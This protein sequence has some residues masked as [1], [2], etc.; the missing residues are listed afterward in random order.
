MLSAE[1]RELSTAKSF[2]NAAA[3][4]VSVAVVVVSG[5]WG[6]H[7]DCDARVLTW[8]TRAGKVPA[9]A[10]RYRGLRGW[11]SH[12]T[13]RWGPRMRK[14]FVNALGAGC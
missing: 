6:R 2:V 4:T 1:R 7:A 12:P 8:A 13:E 14:S 9:Q 5:G 10:G 3:A 11:S